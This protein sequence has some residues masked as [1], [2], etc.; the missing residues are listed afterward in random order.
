MGRVGGSIMMS[1]KMSRGASMS[2]GCFCNGNLVCYMR[3]PSLGC[4]KGGVLF[5]VS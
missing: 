4:Y 2:H 1:T 3:C 5:G